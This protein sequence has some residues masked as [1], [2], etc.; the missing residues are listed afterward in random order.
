MSTKVK[1]CCIKSIEEAR[2]AINTGA[3]AIGLVGPM[4]SGPGVIDDI[5][6]AKIA[7]NVPSHIKTFLLTSEQTAEGILQHYQKVKT[8]TIQIVNYIGERELVQLRKLLPTTELIQVIHV[9]DESSIETAKT[10][11]PLVDGLLLDS[12][13]TKLQVKELGGTGRTHDWGISREIVETVSLPVFL[14]GGINADNVN[15]AIKSVEPYGIDLCSGVRSN[16]D[17]DNIKLRTFFTKVR[18]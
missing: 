10:Y 7:A 16:D 6:I 11:A 15:L 8:T 2:M 9:E 13:N 17:L 12:G 4:P 14:A 1:I 18:S 3:S 5:L